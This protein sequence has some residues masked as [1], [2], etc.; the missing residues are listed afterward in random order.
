[1]NVE[2]GCRFIFHSPPFSEMLNSDSSEP[3][4]TGSEEQLSY[5][6]M[7]NAFILLPSKSRK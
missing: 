1:M 5:S 7:Q 4:T 6:T 3:E 2:A